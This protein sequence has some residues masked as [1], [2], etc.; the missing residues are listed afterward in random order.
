M[1]PSTVPPQ[2][3]KIDTKRGLYP[4]VYVRGFAPTAGAREETFFDTYYGYAQTSV[5]K[6]EAP[7]PQYLE[8][9]VF[10]GQLIRFL[11]EY[12]YVDAANGG[13]TL[14]LSNAVGTTQ[15]PTQSLWIS[16]FYDR[17]VMSGQVRSIEEHGE[18]LR[19]LICE[20]IPTEL[21]KLESVKVDLGQNNQ[22][23]RVIL[24][25][26]SMGGLVCRPRFPGGTCC[27]QGQYPECRHLQGRSNAPVLKA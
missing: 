7:P 2:T 6:R 13:L 8:P 18:D 10:E 25:A 21:R 17:D 19:R 1:S 16:R 11:K 3:F 9:I 12:G 5:E 14:A 27:K 23:Y 22:D 15:N 24:I 4:I 20:T 26:H